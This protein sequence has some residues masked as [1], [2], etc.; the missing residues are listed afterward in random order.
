MTDELTVD[1]YADQT[2]SVSWPNRV[3]DMLLSATVQQLAPIFGQLKATL[4]S[5][6][7]FLDRHDLVYGDKAHRSTVRFFQC[8]RID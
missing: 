3:S 5:R 7:E 8:V 2:N 6:W 1:F 4:F